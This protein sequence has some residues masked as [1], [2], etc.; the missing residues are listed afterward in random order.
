VTDL[1]TIDQ[2]A[3]RLQVHPRT[4][5]R[6]IRSGDLRAIQVAAGSTW[7]ITPGDL[8]EWLASRANRPSGPV[9]RAA[10]PLRAAVARPRPRSRRP[11][12]VLSV[13]DEMGRA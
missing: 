8:D 1:L 6:A 9:A 3:E 4:V 5:S 11:T 13:T 12:G 2:V 7:R 10:V